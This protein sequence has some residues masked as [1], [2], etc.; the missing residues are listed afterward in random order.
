MERED[1]IVE[2]RINDMWI[3]LCYIYILILNRKNVFKIKEKD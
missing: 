1:T 3:R 2:H